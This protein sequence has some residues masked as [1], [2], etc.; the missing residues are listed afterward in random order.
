MKQQR[1]RDAQA[2]VRFSKNEFRK[3]ALKA[4]SYSDLALNFGYDYT[5]IMKFC[6]DHNIETRF[7]ENTPPKQ[8]RKQI[9]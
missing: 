4:T 1:Q 6:R 5:T 7:H 2:P 8:K 9:L 3:A